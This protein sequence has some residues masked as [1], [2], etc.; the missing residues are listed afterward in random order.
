VTA[1]SLRA[2]AQR[3]ANKL[4][5]VHH[6]RK[7]LIAGGG[8]AA[9][10]AMMGLRSLVGGTVQVELLAPEV[11]FSYRP[12]AV[13]EPFGLGEVRRYELAAITADH[14]AHLRQGTLADID[15]ASHTVRTV[16]D[17]VLAYDFLIVAV[18]ARARPGVDGAL[19]FGGAADRDA[20]RRLLEDART[21]KVKRLTFAAPP[22]VGW[23]LPIY[24][25]ALF[26]AAWAR[27]HEV[28]LTLS[29]VT[30][31][32][33]PLESFGTK[34]SDAVAALLADAGIELVTAAVPQKFDGRRLALAEGEPIE[35]D[36]V[37]SL[38][39][40][41]G[42]Y[43]SGLP[44]DEQGFVPTDV[45]GAVAS[46]KD[47]YAAG[48]ATAFPIK[49]GG[50][51]AQQADAVAEAIAA[52]LGALQ[53][54]APFSPVLR[55]LLLGGSERR[56]LRARPGSE[57]GLSSEVAYRPLWWPPSKIAGRHLAPY[58]ADPDDPELMRAP[59]EDRPA[60]I[61]ESSGEMAADEREAIELL[62]EL[63]DAN[64]RRGS[65][66]FALKCLDAAEDLGGPL[67]QRR[68]AERRKWAQQQAR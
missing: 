49:Q 20:M 22:A 2:Y 44:H 66:N 5:A 34:A 65:F 21:G 8:V 50:L 9:L 26:T 48:D 17:E 30:H 29:V 54:P 16:G 52:E 28:S 43:L 59:L 1:V 7:V 63:A 10:E 37:I 42:P 12:I 67:P 24:E 62:L 14:A 45:H 33:R 53:R 35:T 64:A 15:P 27:Q 51:A 6:R 61:V 38:P 36:A 3:V 32:G 60:P 46:V 19:T 25:L 31:E 55:G 23:L 68:V 39:A 56:Y 47:V 57:I 18:G 11:E 4:Q 41:E 58:L 13:A 40:L